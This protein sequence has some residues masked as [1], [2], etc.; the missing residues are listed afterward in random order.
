MVLILRWSLF[1]FGIMFFSMGICMAIN[2]QYL[3]IQ[4]WDVLHVGLYDLFGLTVGTW[5]ILV[6]MCL[7]GICLIIDRTFVQIGTFINIILIGI[8]VDFFL[9]L[10][11]LPKA[12]HTW[13]DILIILIGI[14][15][16][17]L[18]GGMYNSGGVGAGPRDGFML[19]ISHRWGFP[20]RRVRIITETGVLVLGF[21]IGGPV[22][23]FTIL[24]T[25]IQSH[26]F[27]F[28]FLK[29]NQYV[30]HFEMSKKGKRLPNSDISLKN[31]H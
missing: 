23:I 18:A 15:I 17:G 8:F 12:T 27:Q 28:S 1:F 21:I 7:V 30:Y 29:F 2:V 4:S 20:I 13:T 14:V 11:F 19:A 22:F 9:W 3:G 10:D 6:G 31:N 24:F 5:S 26:L 25:F 16:M